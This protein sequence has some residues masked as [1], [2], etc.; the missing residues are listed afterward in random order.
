MRLGVSRARVTSPSRRTGAA[1]RADC[2]S[3]PRA[4]VRASVETP[5][6]QGGIFVVSPPSPSSAYLRSL[7]VLV[8]AM[9]SFPTLARPPWTSSPPSTSPC[10]PS[11]Q[12]VWAP[13]IEP[14]GAPSIACG[15]PRALPPP[16]LRPPRPSPPVTTVRCRRVPPRPSSER[17]RSL[18]ELALLPAPLPDRERRRPRRNR[19]S[20]RPH[21]RGPNCLVL[22]LCRDLC[23][24]Q[25]PGCNVLNLP[26]GPG[27]KHIF[28][29]ISLIAETCKISGKL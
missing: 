1:H 16:E 12:I 10:R 29:S 28:N 4:A 9:P 26:K 11:H 8:R 3:D 5:P 14:P 20:R 2:R 25:G 19:L 18:G 17:Q 27:A 7:P 21:G 22:F 13:S 15:P 23:A 24:R 6:Y